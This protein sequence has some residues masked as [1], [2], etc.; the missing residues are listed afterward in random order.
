MKTLVWSYCEIIQFLHDII[1]M[2]YF[3]DEANLALAAQ[4][5]G[6]FSGANAKLTGWLGLISR[7]RAGR[8]C[9]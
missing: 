3:F 5:S 7:A 1:L 4:V 6:A 9:P 8:R 2:L